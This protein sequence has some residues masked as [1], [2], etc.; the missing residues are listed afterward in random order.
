MGGLGGGAGGVGTAGAAGGFTAV[1][2]EAFAGILTFGFSGAEAVT[3]NG[4]VQKGHLIFLPT[5]SP[6]PL[7]FFK[8]SGQVMTGVSAMPVSRRE[9]CGLRDGSVSDACTSCIRSQDRRR[10]RF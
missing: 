4:L 8:H 9:V 6:R 7:N 1:E 10:R 5:K 2:A 3:T